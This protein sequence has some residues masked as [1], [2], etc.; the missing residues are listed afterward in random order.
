MKDFIL[1]TGFLGLEA[2][3]RASK[4]AGGHLLA[5]TL[6]P[7]C[8]NYQD[9][10]AAAAALLREVPVHKGAARPTLRPELATLRAPFTG[11]SADPAPGHAVNA[12]IDLSAA[13]PGL[14][15]VCLGPLTNLALAI[16][17]EPA[18]C[19]RIGRVVVAGGA[20]LGYNGV[21]ATSEYNIYTDPEAASTVVSCGI[22]VVLIPMEASADNRAAAL[23][24]ALSDGAVGETYEAFI[25]VDVVGSKTYGQT[26][27]DPIGY[28]PIN[29]LRHGGEKHL[30]VKQADDAA[31]QQILGEEI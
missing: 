2:A 18:V 26:V 3:K 28:N 4:A 11:E 22:P 17:K 12:I 19:Q 1:D 14:T 10:V 6:A 25:D 27:I 5:V 20:Q 16:M 24:W 23:A 15:V 30:V 8:E 7:D 13:H 9:L 29:G 21:T 31:V